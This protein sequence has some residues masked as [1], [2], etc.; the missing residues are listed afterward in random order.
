MHMIFVDLEKAYDSIPRSE[1]IP[2]MTRMKCGNWTGQNTFITSRKWSNNSR[3]HYTGCG[4]H[5][6]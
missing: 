4:T 2:A 6:G 1:I 3:K 5:A